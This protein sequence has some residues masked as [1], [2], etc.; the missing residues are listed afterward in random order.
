LLETIVTFCRDEW[1]YLI[2]TTGSARKQLREL[3]QRILSFEQYYMACYR[4]YLLEQLRS[5]EPE[6]VR[7]AMEVQKQVPLA[8]KEVIEAL[9]QQKN[10]FYHPHSNKIAITIKN[11]KG[12]H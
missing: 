2:P 9:Q 11:H 1:Q 10:T 12:Y 8:D 4:T 7:I 5:T 6:H 3:C